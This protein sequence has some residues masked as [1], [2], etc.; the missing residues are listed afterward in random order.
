MKA[1]CGITLG[2]HKINR[3]ALALA[4]L[5]I[6]AIPASAAELE[7][8][9]IYNKIYELEILDGDFSALTSN[10]DMGSAGRALLV[11][12]DEVWPLVEDVLSLGAVARVRYAGYDHEFGY[13]QPTGQAGPPS[14]AARP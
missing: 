7:R 11:N 8:W 6:F 5:F 14:A 2:L 9:E 4:F 12:P 10:T 3:L 1:V 13:Y